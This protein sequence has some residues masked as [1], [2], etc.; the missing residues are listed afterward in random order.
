MRP[1]LLTRIVE[2]LVILAVLW[3]RPK[4]TFDTYERVY[5]LVKKYK[6][7]PVSQDLEKEVRECYES[8]PVETLADDKA[9]IVEHFIQLVLGK[10]GKPLIYA[11]AS[12]WLNA[13]RRVPGQC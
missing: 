1:I 4:G 10:Y 12:F 8:T 3:T 6:A 9:G 5:D 11:C 13:I 2:L 7:S